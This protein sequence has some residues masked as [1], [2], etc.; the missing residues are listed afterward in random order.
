M[1]IQRLFF[2]VLTLGLMLTINSCDTL[3]FLQK[4]KPSKPTAPANKSDG[5]QPYNKV[6]TAKAKSDTG[7]FTVHKV[8]DTYFYEI[9][10]SLFDRE[11][12]MVSRIAKTAANIGYGGEKI[13]TQV[14]R[15]EKQDKNVLLRVIRYDNTA[16]DSLP[17]YQSVKNSNFEPILFSFP[18]KALA[19]DSAGV[20][21][22]VN[23]LFITDVPAL[24]LQSY[25]KKSYG[26]R[27]VDKN[28][29]FLN[30]IHSYP[31]NIEARTTLTY[32]AVTPPSNAS[33]GSISLE[34]NHSM[35]IL[36][37]APMMPRYNDERV[38]F[39]NVSTID[40][41]AEVQRAET[42][43]FITRWRLEPKD[44]EA[45]ARGELTEPIKP[46]I[47]YID[48]A[49]PMKWRPFLKQGVNDWQKAF[50]AAGFK[51]AIYALDPPTVEEDPEF[52]P[53]DARYS[54]IRYFSSDIQNAYG[55]HVHDPR[56]GEILESDIGWYHNVMNLLRNWFFVQTAVINPNAR[57]VNFDDA[58]MGEL[59]R[60]VSSHEVGHTLGL[61]HNMKASSSYPV[62]SLRSAAFTKRMG[63]APSIMDYA[64]FNYIAQPEDG[65]VGLYPA[66]GIYDKY[67]INW[68]YRPILDATTPAEERATLDKWIREK[69]N[70]PM[71]RF[72]DPSYVD[73]SSQTEDLGDDAMKASTYGIANLKRILPNLMEW[74]YSEYSDYSN[75]QELYIQV[76]GQWNRYMGHVATNIGGVYRTRKTVDQPGKVYEVVPKA[77]QQRAMKFLTEQAFNTPTWMINSEILQR[78]EADGAVNR[79]RRYQVGVLQN[80]LH[81]EKMQ[82]LI[83]AETVFNGDVYTIMDL[84]S[85]VRSGVWTELS[86]RNTIDTY[87][88]NLQRAYL[89]RM[90]YLMT[91]EL[92]SY[93]A[94][95]ASYY[96]VTEVDVSQSDIRPIVRGELQRL[97]A[98]I[99][100]ALR[101]I[102]D[103]KTRYHLEDALVRID[104]ILDPDN[105]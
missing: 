77:T 12:L 41:G 1:N 7:L 102:S 26:V 67:A 79:I 93:P 51:N 8:D 50:E 62:D 71:Y 83:E 36:P 38:G 54:V 72:G 104:T 22:E 35:I 61:P 33:M 14:F 88:R 57:S 32:N 96:G 4:S 84:F 18:I 44:P 59:I 6:I 34:I 17:V 30:H 43:T 42:K 81:P 98:D 63:T 25:R 15:W 10:D 47:Y 28:R 19:K 94:W 103:T 39:F 5:I 40:Y 85:D 100:Q 2:L 52:S 9:P 91:E 37:K 74:T 56:S 82:R 64:R 95:Y 20:V 24:G 11:M 87:R 46:I 27:N 45:F 48:P 55:P 70:D 78:I 68:G 58:V 66:I 101:R 53:E 23:D 69:E 105:D 21:I 16:S 89:E 65:D 97:K 31:T 80:V 3:N 75:L 49:T 99:N 29:T 90:Q 92:P 76:L 60:F 13:N 73:P 86:G